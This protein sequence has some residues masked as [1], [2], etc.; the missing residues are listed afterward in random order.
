VGELAYDARSGLDHVIYIEED[1]AYAPYLV[2][3]ADYG[4]N[5]LLLREKLMADTM[6]FNRTGKYAWASYAYDGYYEGSSVDDYLNTDFIGSLGPSA[7]EAIASSERVITDKASMSSTVS[8]T[9]TISRKVF[10]L[11]LRELDGPKLST[12]VPE[13]RT[14]K[15]FADDHERRHATLPDGEPC[16]Y[17]TRT[18][19]TWGTRI[20]YGI[21]AKE[22]GA[23]IGIGGTGIDSGV[24]PAFCLKKATE[25]TRRTDIVDGQTVYAIK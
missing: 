11:S 23:E 24:R 17:W 5:V 18:P 8:K 2:L 20:V 16:P 14:L 12:S 4:G 21:S 25:V 13:G 10:L 19:S 7:R 9:L 6:P 3:T 1:G 15:Y 22:M